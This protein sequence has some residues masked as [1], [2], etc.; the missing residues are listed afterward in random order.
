MRF[1]LEKI[2]LI[3]V[4]DAVLTKDW[5]ECEKVLK[6]VGYENAK[7]Y[8]ICLDDSHRCLYGL[9]ESSLQPCPHCGKQGTIPY[10]Y[11]GLNSKLKLWCKDPEMCRKMTYHMKEK[12]HWP[13]ENSSE[14]WVSEMKKKVWDGKRFFQLSWFWNPDDSWTLLTFCPDKECRL[15]LPAAKVEKEPYLPGSRLKKLT[16]PSC[17]KHFEHEPVKA[18][19]DPRN[20][21][22]ILH[23]DG[24]QSFSGK[25]N[26]DCGALEVQIATM[27][28]DERC[29]SE[30]V[31]VVGFVPCYLLPNKRPLPLDPFL[32][33]FIEE[34]K[35][36]FIEGIEVNYSLDTPW[37]KAGPTKLRHLVLLCTA[38]YPAMCEL[39]KSQFCG[40]SPCRRC[41]CG[42]KRTSEEAT[43]YYYG[44]YRRAARFPWPS[45]II[46]EDI[47]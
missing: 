46:K 37:E 13:Y 7:Q 32:A 47:L 23:W 5:S 6:K 29:K 40:K 36:G 33:A 28:K 45:R 10:Y 34:I 30:E 14:D 20:V 44:D 35:T 38:D 31:F 18:H 16:C 3:T 21:A 9:M 11:I 41:E 42:Y 24:F 22:Y 26:H 19:G 2:G 27:C 12:D 25:E 4:F 1:N 43:T 8:F 17:H 39:C 15:V